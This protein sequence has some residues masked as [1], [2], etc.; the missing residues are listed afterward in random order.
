[1]RGSEVNVELKVVRD[2]QATLILV[3]FTLPGYWL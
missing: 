3:H 1:V 2:D